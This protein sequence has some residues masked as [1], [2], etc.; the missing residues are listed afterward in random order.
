LEHTNVEGIVEDPL[1]GCK[2]RAENEE[3]TIYTTG[4]KS[5]VIIYIPKYLLFQTAQKFQSLAHKISQTTI[6][7]TFRHSQLEINHQISQTDF[8]SSFTNYFMNEIVIRQ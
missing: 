1:H 5:A 8:P 7:Y 2:L 6:S 4:L 3:K